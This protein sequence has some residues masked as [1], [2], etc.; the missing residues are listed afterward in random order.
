MLTEEILKRLY[1]RMAANPKTCAAI[2]PHL[3]SALAEAQVNTKLRL[4]AFMAQVGHESGEF[5][6]M[7]EIW[8]PTPAQLRYEP[9]TT[10]AAR[11]GNTQKGDGFR[12]KGRGPIQLTGR[13]N[14]RACG[15]ALGLPL[16][17]HPEEGATLEVAFRIAGWFW[18]SHRLN[19]LA[20]A[21]DFDGITK[22]INGGTNGKEDRDRR[23]QEALAILT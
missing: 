11:L 7:E 23:Y 9:P 8:G 4:A 1:P 19:V 18:T 13:A 10:L 6:Y 20:D 21:G 5:K 12:Y 22:A 3:A 16:E 2:F 17:D 15:T 14:Y